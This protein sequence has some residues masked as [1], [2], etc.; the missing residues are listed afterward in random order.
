LVDR[1]SWLAAE[2]AAAVSHLRSG[3]ASCWDSNWR[4]EHRRHDRYPENELWEAVDGY[5]ELLDRA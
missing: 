2:L 1:S 3:H 5:L 4:R